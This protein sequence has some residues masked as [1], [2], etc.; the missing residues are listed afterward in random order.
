MPSCGTISVR[1]QF[2]KSNVEIT[3]CTLPEEQ[4]TPGDAVSARV[5]VQNNNDKSARVTV[6]ILLNGARVAQ[7]TNTVIANGSL[8]FGIPFTAPT[9][10]GNFS[11]S[12]TLGS[13]SASA[14]ATTSSTTASTT[15]QATGGRLLVASPQ[16]AGGC[17]GGSRSSYIPAGAPG[18]PVCRAFAGFRQAADQRP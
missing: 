14:P 4:T 1:S 7:E 15:S 11:V 2:S 18:G 9:S 6:N 17:C 8:L 5:R 10:E 16:S 13:V 3:S 12:S